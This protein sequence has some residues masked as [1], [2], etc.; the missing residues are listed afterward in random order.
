VFHASHQEA[1]QV[2]Q[3]TR[4]QEPDDLALALGQELVAAQDAAS[5]SSSERDAKCSSFRVRMSVI[6][7]P[8]HGTCCRAFLV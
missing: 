3:V 2:A 8:S 7:L 1:A 6:V 5:F 4:D